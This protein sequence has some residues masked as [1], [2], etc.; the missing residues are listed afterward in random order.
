[1]KE[2]KLN[3]RKYR[4]GQKIAGIYIGLSTTAGE[5][6]YI[7]DAYG[8]YAD[9]FDK[10]KFYQC[11]NVQSEKPGSG[12]FLDFLKVLKRDLDK[13][14][15]FCT[16]VNNGIYKYLQQAGIGVVVYDGK[17]PVFYKVEA[18][19]QLFTISMKTTSL[20]DVDGNEI[21]VGDT[22]NAQ[23]QAEIDEE[24]GRAE[25]EFELVNSIRFLEKRGYRINPPLS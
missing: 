23:A 5:S 3:I 13:P 24:R 1:M 9:L 25:E 19:K 11:P 17:K 20:F 16:I 18:K 10:G 4:K 22:L 2:V 12:K 7:A 14:V 15:Y 8:I 6:M 21:F